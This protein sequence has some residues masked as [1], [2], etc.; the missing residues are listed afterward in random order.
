MV[1][2]EDA[3]V[4][5]LALASARQVLVPLQR[6]A[7]SKRDTFAFLFMAC[8]LQQAMPQVLIDLR[9]KIMSQPINDASRQLADGC[10][11]A[12]PAAILKQKRFHFFAMGYE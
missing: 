9:Q 2:W 10:D 7:D 11:V 3:T 1:T 8:P 4:P 5:Y 12:I 6:H